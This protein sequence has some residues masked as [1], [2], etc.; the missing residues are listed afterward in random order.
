V[1]FLLRRAQQRD[2]T[3]A[4]ALILEAAP[5]LSLILGGRPAAVRAAEHAFRAERT[6]VSY[7]FAM[8][9]E[10]E[11]IRGLIIAFPGKLFGSLKLGTGVQLAR[12]AGARHAADLVRR[13][14]ML[15]RLIPN[16][17]PD[18]LYVSVL[19]VEPGSRGQ[20]IGSVLLE[21][22]MAAADWMNLGV[23]L[24]VGLENDIARRLYER[25][26]FQVTS[27]RETS[28]T[29]RRQIR[30]RGMARMERRSG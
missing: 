15:D 2:A 25:L 30:T 10:G 9:E 14:R 27:V 3:S 4:A 29:D 12:A 13:G 22:L 19:A 21:R 28:E 1:L 23:A 6:E 17:G 18:V 5:S 8:V 26:G 20:G 16:P 7:R 24:D 11:G